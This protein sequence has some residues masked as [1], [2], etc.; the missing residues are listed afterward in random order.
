M[1]LLLPGEGCPECGGGGGGGASAFEAALQVSNPLLVPKTTADDPPDDEFND[2]AGMSG[3]TNGLAAKWAV[4]AGAVGVVDLLET[5]DVAEYDLTSRA[6]VMLTQAGNNGAQAVKMRQD[7]TLP[8][9]AS[10]NVAFSTPQFSANVFNA[11]RVGLVLNDS[12]ADT[13]AGSWLELTTRTTSSGHNLQM[14]DGATTLQ[15]AA[16]AMWGNAGI[17][18]LKF[19][20]DGLDYYP[21]ASLDGVSWIPFSP[22]TKAGA[23]TNMWIQ[24]ENAAAF[25]QEP[26]PVT[27]WFWV[28]QG[29]NT[30]VPW[31]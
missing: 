20:R 22:Y 5:G 1:A 19:I 28:R 31:S 24:D 26:V 30:L 29:D 27:T 17:T 4:T 8:D 18:F 25:G 12:D 16:G 9:G 13:R 10:I 3:V 21:F 23:M 15:S 2:A 6:E 14:T 7:W 11:K